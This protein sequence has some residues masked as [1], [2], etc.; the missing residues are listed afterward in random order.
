MAAR[1]ASSPCTPGPLP[2]GDSPRVL[3]LR[4]SGLRSGEGAQADRDL[5]LPQ[6]DPAG[7]RGPS[8]HR[9]GPGCSRWRAGSEGGGRPGPGG[10]SRGPEEDAHRN[11]KRSRTF[12]TREGSGR[13]P[14]SRAPGA[15]LR[16]L[17][18]T[19]LGR[20]GPV[21]TLVLFKTGQARRPSN[22]VQNSLP[23]PCQAPGLVP[24]PRA[25]IRF[26]L[27]G[28]RRRGP[29]RRAGSNPARLGRS[30]GRPAPEGPAPPSRGA[31][32]DGVCLAPG[33]RD[34][35]PGPGT[36]AGPRQVLALRVGADEDKGPRPPHGAASGL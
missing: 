5:P 34:P 1:P 32:R 23:S 12:R 30:P 35:P 7:E 4:Y 27:K 28:R 22:I 19:R 16:V 13:Q 15:P 21:S 20:A 14:G 3:A 9:G 31:G 10:S 29:S 24:A 18:R 33:V 25:A 8:T 2:L 26:A 36:A 17:A 6:I 11:R